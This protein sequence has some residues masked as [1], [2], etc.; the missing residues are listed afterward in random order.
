VTPI[1]RPLFE[2]FTDEQ[3]AELAQPATPAAAA[4][5]AVLE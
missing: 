1:D 4:D 5:N 2:R 3:L